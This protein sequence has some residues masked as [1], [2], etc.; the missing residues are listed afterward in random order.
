MVG[1]SPHTGG[2]SS[3]SGDEAEDPRRRAAIDSVVAALDF[4]TSLSKP[5]TKPISSPP[6]SHEANDE[7]NK[8]KSHA[9]KLY[10][11]KAQ[12]L[13]DDLLDKSLVMVKTSTPSFDESAQR[14]EG[15]IRLFSQAP[16]GI[17]FD[18]ID[19]YQR[20]TKRPK[21]LPTEEINEKS[22]K[23]RHQVQSVAVDGSD[24]IAAAKGACHRALAR[25]E[26]KEIAAKAAAKREEERVAELKRTRGEKW[27][28]S[29]A[30]DMQA[31]FKES[32]NRL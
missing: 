29:I 13:L 25:F 2:G 12:K 11:I 18:P 7:E 17:I 27:L 4:S 15:G 9:F 10:Q 6:Q 14:S 3:S 5:P 22:R 31:S 8:P 26:A 24:I 23:F 30:R 1:S 19:T 28:P 21:I 32:R 20:P 16:P